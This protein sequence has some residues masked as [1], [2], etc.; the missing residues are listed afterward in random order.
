MTSFLNNKNLNK[1][2]EDSE[3]SGKPDVL[4]FGVQESGPQLSNNL[5]ISRI[6]TTGQNKKGP[7]INK[8][9]QSDPSPRSLTYTQD[10]CPYKGFKMSFLAS[11]VATVRNSCWRERAEAKK[12]AGL[13]SLMGSMRHCSTLNSLPQSGWEAGQPKANWL[14]PKARPCC[15]AS[16]LFILSCD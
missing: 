13:L 5:I 11:A 10:K 3:G 12:M 8:Q 14:D 15:P 4:Y 7:L 1:L 9:R 6:K 2:Q 16:L